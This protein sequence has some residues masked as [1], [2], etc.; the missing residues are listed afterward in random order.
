MR[1]LGLS[2]LHL[3]HAVD[4]PMDVF[5]EHWKDHPARIEAAW[6]EE[7]REDDVV[8]CPGDLSWGMTLDQARP[9]VEFL[10]RLP[11]RKVLV[12]GNHDYWWQSV[13]RIRAAW[14]EMAFL[15]NDAV[16]FGGVGVCGT[17]GWALPGMPEYGAEDEKYVKRELER[18]R[19]S[20]ERLPIADVRVAILHHPPCLAEL[21]ETLWTKLLEELRI[22]WCV[23]GHLH[24]PHA[25]PPVEGRRG[26]VEYRCVSAD[27]VGFRPI[28]L[29][30]R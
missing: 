7:V 16:D 3:G 8:L 18:L 30:E 12:K 11:G 21:P 29:F 15:Q 4:K 20:A 1:F 27:H 17:R 10:A 9:D 23:Y 14:P 13:S 28:V 26:R 24:L 22:D 25:T 5:G 6:R 19:R 2:D